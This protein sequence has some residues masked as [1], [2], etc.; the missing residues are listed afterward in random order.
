MCLYPRLIKNPKYRPNKKNKG[1]VPDMK[2]IRVGYVPIGCGLC[3]ECMKQKAN[4]WKVRLMEEIKTDKRGKFVTL[5]FSNEHY[6]KLIKVLEEKKIKATGYLLDNEIA[7]IAVRRFLE[8]W[9]K[10]HKKS[11][12][13]WLITELGQGETEHLHLHGILFTDEIHK[14]ERIWKYGY[15]WRGK[16]KN[17]MIINYVNDS[18]IS[19]MTKY[20]TKTDIKHKYYKAKIFTSAGIGSNYVNTFNATRN[21]FKGKETD[22][23]YTTRDGVKY[24]L[25][26]YWRNKI[27][28]EK[29]REEL[30]LNQL[31]LN[32]RYVG[33]E[34]VIGD[35]EKA[36]HGLL[37]H[38]RKLN[39][40]M[41]YGAPDNWV[42]R[43]YE[44]KRRIIMQHKRM[45]NKKDQ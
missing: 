38:Y 33:G 12:K 28:T 27:Y 34:A 24:N 30:W 7:T 22:T 13:H 16:K 25:P 21:K 44:H 45:Q 3:M 37:Y 32:I 14:L 10:E 18:T 42:A 17:G 19:Y 31:D 9:R 43:E 35:N 8:R 20:V 5:T 39:T 6:T 2:D 40:E 36:Y 29:E 26:I 15:V 4:G 41:G 11:V 1:I 23:T